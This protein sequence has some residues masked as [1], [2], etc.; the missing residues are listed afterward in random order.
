MPEKEESLDMAYPIIHRSLR[1]N[2]PI[3]DR[4]GWECETFQNTTPANHRFAN[5][6][7]MD[8]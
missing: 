2:G 1:N 7:T 5:I 6:V 3:P 8:S 4:T